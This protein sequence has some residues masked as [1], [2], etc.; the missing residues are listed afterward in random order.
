MG[1]VSGEDLE[2]GQHHDGA[3]VTASKPHIH[4]LTHRAPS[5][6]D[7]GSHQ[8]ASGSNCSGF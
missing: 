4:G 1:Y 3:Q 6:M 2:R 5:A 7:R 8:S